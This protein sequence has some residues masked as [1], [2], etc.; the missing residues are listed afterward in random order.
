MS[1][2]IS[3]YEAAFL[4][5]ALASNLGDLTDPPLLAPEVI[6]AVEREVIA[7]GFVHVPHDPGFVAFLESEGV[8]PSR[9]YV[10]DNPQISGTLSIFHSSI[11]LTV[12][13]DAERAT[14]S[15]EFMR[16]LGLHLARTLGL[17]FFDPQAGD[18]FFGES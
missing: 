17:G 9:D 5:D 7:R 4:R 11:S 3:L 14:A 16:S 13:Y 2:D 10:L 8:T 12:G 6:A 1:Y 15:V 18:S